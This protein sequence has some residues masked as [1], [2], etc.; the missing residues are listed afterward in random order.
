MQN[1]FKNNFIVKELRCLFN[2][3]SDTIYTPKCVVCACA[4]SDGFL[5][6]NCAKL[7][8]S[9]AGFTQVKI[10]GVDVY[11]VFL[12]EN[13]LKTLI[14]NYKFKNKLKIKSLFA[15]FL[16]KYF[17]KNFGNK[18]FAVVPVPSHKRRISKR[19]YD[20]INL[21]AK[22][23]CARADLPLKTNI[24]FKIKDTHAHFNLNKNQ[25]AKNIRGS[26]VVKKENYAGESLLIL[27]DITTTG[28][29]LG[30]V[31]SEFKKQGIKNLMCLTLCKAP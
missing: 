17:N 24:L 8:T 23:F 1:F 31:I 27:D 25:R 29:T 28:A 6:K 26:F 30:E 10:K 12:Y 4:K 19:G 14:Q 11:S 2:W 16:F 22:E 18:K 3:F 5:C 21:I 15:E 13:I 7:I 9:A 20:H